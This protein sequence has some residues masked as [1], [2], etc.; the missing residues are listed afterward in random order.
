MKT[1]NFYY[2]ISIEENGKFLAFA[3]TLNN[4]NNLLVLFERYKNAKNITACSTRKDA[5]QLAILWNED[6]IKNDTHM[7]V[8]RIKKPYRVLQFKEDFV[9]CDL[10]EVYVCNAENICGAMHEFCE[11]WNDSAMYDHTN[12]IITDDYGNEFIC[13]EL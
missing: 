2:A 10:K 12:N 3:E 4:W 11:F 8:K 5:E 6:Y 7:Y 9:D 13:R 1:K